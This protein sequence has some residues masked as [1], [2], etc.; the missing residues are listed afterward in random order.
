MFC[1]MCSKQWNIM[2]RILN[3]IIVEEIVQEIAVEETPSPAM[4]QVIKNSV[5]KVEDEYDIGVVGCLLQFKSTHVEK[6]MRKIEELSGS[7]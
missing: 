6:G 4:D 5:K 3:A 1:L 2:K 7:E